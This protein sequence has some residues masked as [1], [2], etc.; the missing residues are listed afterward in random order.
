MPRLVSR[1]PGQVRP[2]DALTSGHRLS[3][4]PGAARRYARRVIPTTG[5]DELLASPGSRYF[6][7]P[8][9][10]SFIVDP[11]LVGVIV[12]DRLE[13][14]ELLELLRAHER[15]RPVLAPRTAALVD[16]RH[17]ELPDPAAFTTMVSY[18]AERSEWLA[19]YLD[20]L[21]LVRTELGV[22]AATAA[23]FF[24]VTARPFAARTFT[25]LAG[26]LGWLGRGDA[27]DLEADL[28]AIY[29]EASGT[30]PLL[31]KLRALLEARPGALALEH[32]S[33]E[34]AMTGRSLQRGLKSCGTTFQ[35]EQNRAQVRVAQRLLGQSDAALEQVASDVGCASLSHFSAL[36]R[37]VTGE[38]P[39][40]WRRHHRG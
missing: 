7:R 36:F 32:A 21:A 34:L 12:W 17:L 1:R 9:S 13:A 24:D 33:R 15:M 10:L 18:L 39:T 30:P 2:R 40:D 14:G 38:T 31:R 8:R 25:D 27:A 3:S 26:A 28:E 35:A 23:G 16:A 37:R 11:Q 20:R 6:T 19:E 22:V 4:P 5:L 29:A